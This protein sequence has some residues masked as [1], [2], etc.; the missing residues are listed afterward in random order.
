MAGIGGVSLQ[1]TRGD[2]SM[3]RFYGI[4]ATI[5]GLLIALNLS[6]DITEGSRVFWTVFDVVLVAWVCL[7]N[8]WTRNKL[9]QL[10]D[11][12]AKIEKR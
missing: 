10:A 8:P 2:T 6:I 5:S 12:L 4:Y 3:A 11:Y 7:F 1:I 9:I